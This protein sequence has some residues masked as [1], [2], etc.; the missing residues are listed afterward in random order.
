MSITHE[1][2]LEI[3]DL[4]SVSI[5]CGTCKTE[6]TLSIASHPNV[7]FECPSCGTRFHDE[8]SRSVKHFMEACRYL[9]DR[10]NDVILRVKQSTD[11]PTPTTAQS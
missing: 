10:K 4:H 5:R 3:S 1:L 9:A 7:P 6:I 8:Y 2:L 11:K